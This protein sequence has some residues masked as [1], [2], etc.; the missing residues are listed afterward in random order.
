RCLVH[1]K[2]RGALFQLEAQ[3]LH[4]G[5]DGNDQIA[6]RAVSEIIGAQRGAVP[7][8]PAIPATIDDMPESVRPA[9]RRL[10]RRLALGVFLDAWPAR[11]GATLPPG[12]CP[13]PRCT[14]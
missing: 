12:G 13:T 10:A 4:R 9:L 6:S 14:G 2:R 11:A 5:E 7:R 8:I 1:R 3:R